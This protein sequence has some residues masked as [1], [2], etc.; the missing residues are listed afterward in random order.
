VPNR[1]DLI[2]DVLIAHQRFH[3]P[4]STAKAVRQ[5]NRL[6]SRTISTLSIISR[7]STAPKAR[8]S[9]LLL[10]HLGRV[11]M[12][13]E[14]YQTGGISEEASLPNPKITLHYC[15]LALGSLPSTSR[16]K[17]SRLFHALMLSRGDPKPPKSLRGS[18]GHV[19]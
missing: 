12:L 13:R 6:T 10:N 3:Q 19:I 7:S 15:S 1:S 16:S 8:H 9:Y 18:S 5:A 4:K 14:T 11:S 17:N 2:K